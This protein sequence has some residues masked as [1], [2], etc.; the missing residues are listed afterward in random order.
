MAILTAIRMVI[1]IIRRRI[2][3]RVEGLARIQLRRRVGVEG[4]AHRT[5][6]RGFDVL[7]AM[8]FGYVIMLFLLSL[9]SVVAFLGLLSH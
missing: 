9:F 6:L 3:S 7:L 8:H 2:M 4:R 5:R 1:I